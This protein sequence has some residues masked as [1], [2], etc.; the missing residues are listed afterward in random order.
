[1]RVALACN[2]EGF[3]HVS[4]T[5]AFYEALKD[6]YDLVILAPETV[7]GFLAEKLPDARVFSVPHM[8]LAKISDRINFLRTAWENMP[9]LLT[10]RTRIVRASRLLRELG[11][12]VLINDYEPFSAIAAKR[13]GIPVLQF[14]HPGIVVQSPS[15]MPDALAVKLVARFMM[16][17]FDKR[18]FCSFYNGD[19][20]PMIRRELSEAQVS[21]QDYYVVS[22]KES[23]RRPVLKRL[24]QMGIH[25]YRL[26]PN[27]DDDYVAAVANCRAV[28]TS[29]GHQTLS[30]CIHMGKPVFA[31][32]QRG[33]YEQRL[34]ARMLSASGWGSYGSIRNLKRT[35]GGFIARLD[36]YPRKAQPWIKFNFN[37]ETDRIMKKVESFIR[38]SSRPAILPIWSFLFPDDEKNEDVHNLWGLLPVKSREM[39]DLRDR[40]LFR[41]FRSHEYY[42]QSSSIR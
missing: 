25:N 18:I 13:I 30:E 35:L 41:Q 40:R 15:I 29:A 42:E 39:E 36:S 38:H 26:F 21:R 17:S 8:H 2:G 10:L 6:R 12:D 24:H 37:N 1:M 7:H 4:R 5:T 23:Y 32:P 34:N 11:V 20:G 22:L 28:I 33:Q 3:G 14:N 31:I 9:T 16:P 27:P 19:V